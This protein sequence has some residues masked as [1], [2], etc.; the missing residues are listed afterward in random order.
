MR[1]DK[2]NAT[3]VNNF[4]RGIY[5]IKVDES[6]NLFEEGEELIINY[7]QIVSILKMNG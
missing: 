3:V 6:L 1:D 2:I 4:S 7:K 5:I